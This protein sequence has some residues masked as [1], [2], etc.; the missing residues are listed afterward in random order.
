MMTTRSSHNILEKRIITV[1]NMRAVL[2]NFPFISATLSP[3]KILLFF[4]A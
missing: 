2:C 3:E 4:A 1:L